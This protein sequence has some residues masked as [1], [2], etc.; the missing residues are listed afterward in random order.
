PS[1]LR[2]AAPGPQPPA[3]APQAQLQKELAAAAVRL[4]H[5]PDRLDRTI[6]LAARGD[7]RFRTVLAEDDARLL[8]TLVNRALLAAV[9]GVLL[10]T[11]ALLLAAARDSRAVVGGVTMYEIFGYGGVVAGG[12][13]GLRGGGPGGRGG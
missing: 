5:L 7:L 12:G 4:R 9:G 2:P 8:R 3:R 1:S 13:V 11:S 10:L 6:T